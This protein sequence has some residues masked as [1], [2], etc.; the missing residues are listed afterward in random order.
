MPVPAKTQR[1][2]QPTFSR[3]ATKSEGRPT[4]TSP[5]TGDK[6]GFAAEAPQQGPLGRTS[7]LQMTQ[8]TQS[9]PARIT[10]GNSRGTLTPPLRIRCDK[11]SAPRRG[12]K[13]LTTSMSTS[14]NRDRRSRP[15]LRRL[16]PTPLLNT[17]APFEDLLLK[18]WPVRARPS[19]NSCTA[20]TS[21]SNTPC[22]PFL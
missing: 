7:P 19:K 6:D 9:P 13:T 21:P 2:P 11:H 16:G 4:D 3:M 8:N 10:K 22:P 20:Q 1:S 14:V 18:G 15:E 12:N 17:S 5:A